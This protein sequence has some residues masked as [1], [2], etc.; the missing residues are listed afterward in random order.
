MKAKAKVNQQRAGGGDQE[1]ASQSDAN[2]AA[3]PL[4]KYKV[5]YT[6]RT[7]KQLSQAMGEMKRT[8][9]AE[10]LT[11]VCLASRNEY[12]LNEDVRSLS[13]LTEKNQSCAEK[14]RCKTLDKCCKY[15]R[16]P[17]PGHRIG[18]YSNVIS[19]LQSVSL[20]DD[21]PVRCAV[22][23][24][25]NMIEAGCRKSGCAY[26][27]AQ[28]AA[29]TDNEAAAADVVFAPYNYIFNTAITL[30]VHN[31]VIIFDEGHNIEQTCE[32][33]G[34]ADISTFTLMQC[35]KGLNKLADDNTPQTQQLMRKYDH[36][37]QESLRK[38]A[39]FAEELAAAITSR[40]NAEE[41]KYSSR[42]TT[43]ICKPPITWFTGLLL[44]KLSVAGE[45][46][47]ETG[48]KSS[49]LLG[50]QRGVF[51]DISMFFAEAGYKIYLDGKNDGSKNFLSA[52]NSFSDFLQNVFRRR[53][54]RQI[55]RSI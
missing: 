18:D 20:N 31:T 14:R 17:E 4:P 22:I 27:A 43:D 30:S 7:H 15:F 12:C 5:I 46:N 55:E 6:A 37:N 25:E 21:V 40:A 34:S 53:R 8:D 28:F 29:S 3:A 49:E 2:E 32:D 36:M 10:K 44:G 16:P 52:L 35:S 48:E 23:D 54:R 47:L 42:N 13:T 24:V 26:Y 41:R 45:V 9:Y 33:A 50:T 11:A 38:I 1:S 19:S 51:R 39:D